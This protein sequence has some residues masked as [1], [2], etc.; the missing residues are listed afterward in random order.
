MSK[1]SKAIISISACMTLK[2]IGKAA[3]HKSQLQ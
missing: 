3:R 2:E 1:I